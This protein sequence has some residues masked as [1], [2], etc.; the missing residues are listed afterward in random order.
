ME[1]GILTW[2]DFLLLDNV[3]CE[4]EAT[5]NSRFL[6]YMDSQNCEALKSTFE[7]DVHYDPW[8]SKLEMDSMPEM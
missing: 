3:D 4:K 7:M 2:N 1:K 8:R 6:F 5:G